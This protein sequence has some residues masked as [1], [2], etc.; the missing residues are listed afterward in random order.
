[1]RTKHCL[2]PSFIQLHCGMRCISHCELF[3]QRIGSY[4]WKLLNLIH[5][6]PFGNLSKQFFC[7]FVSSMCYNN[8]FPDNSRVFVILW[9]LCAPSEWFEWNCRILQS[10]SSNLLCSFSAESL[11]LSSSLLVSGQFPCHCACL[12]WLLSG[13]LLSGRRAT[14]QAVGIKH[15]QRSTIFSS[16]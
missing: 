5:L 9:L 7:F 6:K 2:Y 1:M 16:G 10:R 3:I 15:T 4:P 12:S 13:Y 14:W 11:S 8:M